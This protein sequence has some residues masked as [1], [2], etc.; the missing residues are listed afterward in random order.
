VVYVGLSVGMS[1]SRSV[2]LVSPAKTAE[3]IEIPFGLKTLVRSGNHMLD[4]DPGSS[5]G[6]GNVLGE[7]SDPL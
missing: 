5:T 3:R 6:R 2:T 7:K 1:V 4:G